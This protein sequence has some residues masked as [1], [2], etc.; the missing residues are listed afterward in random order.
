MV[1]YGGHCKSTYRCMAPQWPTER[2]SLDGEQVAE[3]A[4]TDCAR[5]ESAQGN[6]ESVVDLRGADRE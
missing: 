4:Y 5:E 6:S 3:Q 1:E 2:E